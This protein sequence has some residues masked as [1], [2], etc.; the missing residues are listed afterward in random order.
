MIFTPEHAKVIDMAVAKAT[1]PLK[2]QIAELT[3][4]KDRLEWLHSEGGPDPEGYTWGVFRVKW[5]DEGKLVDVWHTYSD[6][7]DLD[8][9]MSREKRTAKQSAATMRELRKYHV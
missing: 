7:S 1:R 6:F 8:A 4:Y 3:R 2:K 9:E 5:N